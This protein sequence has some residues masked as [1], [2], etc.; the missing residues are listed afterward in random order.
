[1]IWVGV[2]GGLMALL[3]I[4]AAIA[5][6]YREAE[7]EQLELLETRAERLFRLADAADELRAELGREPSVREIYEAAAALNEDGTDESAAADEAAERP[8]EVLIDLRRRVAEIVT[9]GAVGAP[10]D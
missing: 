8:G 6:G 2:F 3:A 4:A 5:V 10:G 7:E 1:M 9:E